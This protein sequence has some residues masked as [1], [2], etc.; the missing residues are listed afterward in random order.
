MVFA[1]S[2]QRRPPRMG[3]SL[4]VGEVLLSST[5]SG[6]VFGGLGCSNL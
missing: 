5:P 4:S 3:R 2:R 1:K 6:Y